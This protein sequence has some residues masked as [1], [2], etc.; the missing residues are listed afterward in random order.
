MGPGV[1]RRAGDRRAVWWIAVFTVPFVREATLG[2][3]DPV[4]VAVFDVPLFVGASAVAALAAA[5]SALAAW[6]AWLATGWTGFVTAS[7]AVYAAVTTEAGW[8]VVVMAAATFCSAVALSLVQLGRVPTEWLLVGPFSFRTAR[9]EASVAVH[10]VATAAQIV[11]FWGFFLVAI[12]LVLAWLEGRWRIEL[13]VV[14]PLLAAPF[15]TVLGF[16]VLALASA[17]GMWSAVAMSTRGGG[18]PLPRAMANRLV[19][20]GP[21]RYVRNPMALAGIVQGAAVG[22]V[23]GSWLVVAYAIAGSLVWNY[24]IRPHEEADLERRFGEDFERYR[25]AVRCWCPR[26][27]PVPASVDSHA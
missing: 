17:L 8:G 4:L 10:F 3:L 13:P 1:L 16:V 5:R 22:L 27:T 9:A 19:V 12:P 7:L 23:L 15:V 24:A 26:L 20:A 2:G 14:T 6:S 11:V 25:D 21:Y 18:T